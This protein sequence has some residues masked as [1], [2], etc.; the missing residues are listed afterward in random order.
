M[1]V[2][3]Y[4]FKSTLNTVYRVLNACDKRMRD[5]EFLPHEQSFYAH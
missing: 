2:T 5:C 1:C 4:S 3:E